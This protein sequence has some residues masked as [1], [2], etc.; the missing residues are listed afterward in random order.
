MCCYCIIYNISKNNLVLNVLGYRIE[1]DLTPIVSL[2]HFCPLSN[3]T[4]HRLSGYEPGK[5]GQEA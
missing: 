4:I 3:D 1:V 2:S 5:A